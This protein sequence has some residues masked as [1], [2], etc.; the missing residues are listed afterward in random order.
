M[1]SHW[2]WSKPLP[3]VQNALFSLPLSY[4][5]GQYGIATGTGRKQRH[6]IYN[7]CVTHLSWLQGQLIHIVCSIAKC[8]LCPPLLFTRISIC[9]EEFQCQPTDKYFTHRCWNSKHLHKKSLVRRGGG[10]SFIQTSK[11]WFNLKHTSIAIL[12]MYSSLS[13]SRNNF[14]WSSPLVPHV[15]ELTSKWNW[16]AGVRDGG[17]G[18]GWSG[19]GWRSWLTSRSQL[20][21]VIREHAPKSIQL[22]FT[23]AII[24][25][26]THTAHT[27]RKGGRGK[28]REACCDWL[29]KFITLQKII[30]SLSQNTQC[31]CNNKISIVLVSSI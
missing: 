1:L 3:V 17:W 20:D 19:M 7:S 22:P 8:D 9:K 21:K 18:W 15:R 10:Q 23:P 14:N 30:R 2:G 31:I 12:L 5:Q 29:L 16:G 13:K 25:L 11:G 26:N 27:G 4:T 28:R 24:H 6:S